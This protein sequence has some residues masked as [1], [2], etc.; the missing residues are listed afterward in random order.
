MTM[1]CERCNMERRDAVGRYTGMIES[2]RYV[3]PE[4][5]EISLEEGY[6]RPTRVDFRL[7]WLE[8]HLNGDPVPE[9]EPATTTKRR[10]Q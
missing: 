3:Q 4:G 1:R 10:K 5:Y 7:E 9:P 6:D 2:R 8:A